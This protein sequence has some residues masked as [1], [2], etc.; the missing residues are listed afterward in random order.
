MSRP[1]LL[2]GTLVEQLC[3][4]QVE[5][6]FDAAP[7]DI[8]QHTAAKLFIDLLTFSADQQELDLVVKIAEFPVTVVTVAAVLDVLQPMVMPNAYRPNDF[9]RE[10][11]VL[12]ELIEAP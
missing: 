6:P 10:D 7:R 1:L 8:R 3:F 5:F 9:L 4:P 2:L 11:S 12:R